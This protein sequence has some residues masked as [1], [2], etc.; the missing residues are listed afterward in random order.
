MVSFWNIYWVIYHKFWQD[1]RQ[2]LTHKCIHCV[3]FGYTFSDFCKITNRLIVKRWKKIKYLNKIEENRTKPGN[4]YY[5][6]LFENRTK[7]GTVLSETVLSGDLYYGTM[8]ANISLGD[9]SQ[10]NFFRGSEK[11]M[12]ISGCSLPGHTAC[13]N[14]LA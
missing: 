5:L 14:N 10:E 8:F 12:L 1:F 3:I 6:V 9:F 2:F 4:P 13:Q 7:P 11:I